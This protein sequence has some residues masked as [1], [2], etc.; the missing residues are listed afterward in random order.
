M[1]MTYKLLQR[2]IN[3]RT[4]VV[5]PSCPQGEAAGACSLSRRPALPAAAPRLDPLEDEHSLHMLYDY[6]TV[7][8]WY[9]CSDTHISLF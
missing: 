9:V 8:A 1:I 4:Q 6:S 2:S 7:Y 5:I 3:V